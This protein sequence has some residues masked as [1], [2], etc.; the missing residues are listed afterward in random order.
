MSLPTSYIA[1]TSN[2]FAMQ[3]SS[4]LVFSPTPTY[5]LYCE[6]E[7]SLTTVGF[8]DWPRTLEAAMVT[9]PC[10]SNQNAASVRVCMRGGVWGVIDDAQCE[11]GSHIVQIL[12]EL[13]QVRYTINIM[14]A[15]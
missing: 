13:H 3:S 4:V 5:S 2:N 1:T 12:A 7:T 6:I 14:D 9:V 15:S 11:P 8:I 10:P